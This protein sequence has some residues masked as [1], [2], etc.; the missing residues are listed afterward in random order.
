MARRLSLQ[1]VGVLA[2][3][4]CAVQATH[5]PP[6]FGN[7]FGQAGIN[8]TYDYIVVGGGTAGLAVANRLAEDGTK[9]VALVEAGGFYEVYV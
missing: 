7:H 9:M 8:A 2:T 4:V 6:L 5:Y 3:I 1:L